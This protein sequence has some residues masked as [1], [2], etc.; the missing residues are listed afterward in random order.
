MH[1]QRAFFKKGGVGVHPQ[2]LA[3][4]SMFGSCVLPL[5]LMHVQSSIFDSLML[6]APRRS[7]LMV[8][9]R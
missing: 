3:R 5:V 1:R 7:I 6:V 9:E 8:K 2:V 4:V